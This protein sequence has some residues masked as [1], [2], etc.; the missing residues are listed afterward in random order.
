LKWKIKSENRTTTT[1][2]A[3]Q[4]STLYFGRDGLLLAVDAGT[5][6]EK[7]NR[8]LDNINTSAPAV[9]GDTVYAG[10]WEELYA[11]SA[12]T[13]EV[14]WVFR[15]ESGSDDSYF[16]DPVVY[17]GTVYFGGW[18]HFY[19]LDS[20]TGQE[21]WKL[22]LDAITRSVPTVNDGTVYV[23]TFSPDI[24]EAGYLYA[25]DSKTGQEKWKLKATGG[26]IGGAVAV[27]DGVVYVST[28]DDGLLALDAKSG[29]VKWRSNIE[30]SL[31]AAPAVAYGT[32]YITGRVLY[33]VDA[34]TGK[35]KWRLKGSGDFNYDPVIADG[36][37]YFGS[38]GASLGVFLGGPLNSN[39]HAVDAHSGEELWR[40]SV[41][42]STSGDPAISNGTLYFGSDEGHF[43][44]VK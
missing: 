3:I 28:N 25:L 14:K 21:K 43:Y 36:I 4:G 19:A 39:I 31:L 33:A 2:P 32:V 37:I 40:F 1:S 35:E 41:D 12:D 24:G 30:S 27:T 26:G 22:K 8:K 13:G 7:W 11:L 44:A 18:S 42:G 17:D 29:Q 23:G 5:G 9:A 16:D 10:G 34:R 6:T 15:P 20:E 38:T